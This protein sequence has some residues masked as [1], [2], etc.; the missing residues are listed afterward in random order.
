MA[1]QLAYPLRIAAG[2]V[3]VLKRPAEEAITLDLAREHCRIDGDDE[4]V[5][6]KGNIVAAREALEGELSR[7]LLPQECR[8]RIDSFPPDRVLLWNDVIEIIDV[9]YT[10]DAGARQVLPPAAYRVMDR[11]YLVARKAFPYGEDV[12]VRFRC[13]A[14][15]TPDAVPESLIAWMLLQLGTLSEH[16]ES[17]VDGTVSSLSED[18][19]NRLI[20]RHAIVSI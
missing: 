19:T 10:D 13:G 6:L 17:E 15:E 11:A 4:D 7:P 2:R 12:Q 5:L 1:D 3:D 20:G 9:S 14:F 16:R 18:F 8:V